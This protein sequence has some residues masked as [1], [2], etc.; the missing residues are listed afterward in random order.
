MNSDL[1]AMLVILARKTE[2]AQQIWEDKRRADEGDE[3]DE[4]QDEGGE[5]DEDQDEGTLW[6]TLEV[7]VAGPIGVTTWCCG[8][9][10]QEDEATRWAIKAC[11][12]T[13]VDAA[14]ALAELL[15]KTP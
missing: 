9:R 1:A 12:R 2:R 14:Q 10:V 11:G 7:D 13:P 8:Y 15:Q 5:Y 3:Y 4:D 6:L